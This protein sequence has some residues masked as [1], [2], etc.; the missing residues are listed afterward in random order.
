MDG[1][2][3]GGGGEGGRQRERQT[4]RDRDTETR[5]VVVTGEKIGERGSKSANFQ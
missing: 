1:P 4:D 2:W 3:R 5:L